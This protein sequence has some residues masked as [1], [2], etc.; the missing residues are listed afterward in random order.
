M[1]GVKE[2]KKEIKRRSITQP[3]LHELFSRSLNLYNTHI[4]KREG[5]LI[6]KRVR[7]VQHLSFP[8]LSLFY[9]F[10]SNLNVLSYR[11]MSNKMGK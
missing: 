6:K 5:F 1:R 10:F 9:K 4:S 7:N 8:L 11:E 2:K 3:I